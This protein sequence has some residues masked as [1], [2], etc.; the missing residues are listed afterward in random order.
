MLEKENVIVGLLYKSGLRVVNKTNDE[1]WVQVVGEMN[2]VAK[3]PHIIVGTSILVPSSCL[4]DFDETDPVTSAYLHNK[5]HFYNGMY[6]P[7]GITGSATIGPNP[8]GSYG[9]QLD[10]VKLPEVY[11]DS[12]VKN[13]ICLVEK[14][15]KSTWTSEL[16]EDIAMWHGRYGNNN[17]VRVDDK[18]VKVTPIPEKQVYSKE[19]VDKIV[20]ERIEENKR[21]DSLIP[22][23]GF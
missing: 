23:W 4:G 13:V 7:C 20:F 10:I 15:L 18:T 16:E 1:N 6:Y 5:R 11:G 12:C 14:D 9:P 2:N 21:W 3:V 17:Q 19:E 8:T 22:Q